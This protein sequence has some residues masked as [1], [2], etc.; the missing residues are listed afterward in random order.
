MHVWC[1]NNHVFMLHHQVIEKRGCWGF[2]KCIPFFHGEYDAQ[3]MDLR[4]IIQHI[5]CLNPHMYIY[6]FYPHTILNFRTNPHKINNILIQSSI[7]L[8]YIICILIGYIPVYSLSEVP[9][10]MAFYQLQVLIPPIHR[11]YN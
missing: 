1:L 9:T 8:V 4:Y 10:I 2:P 11:M 6:Q 3:L 5:S 7:I